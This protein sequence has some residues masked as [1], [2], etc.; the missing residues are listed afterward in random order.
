MFA[1]TPILLA[2]F[3]GVFWGALLSIPVGP[4]NLT[5]LN[6]GAHK[7]FKWALLIGLGASLMEMIYC[8]IA[9]TGFANFFAHGYHGYVKAALQ[10]CSFVFLLGLGVYFLTAPCPAENPSLENS[11][12][13]RIHPHA[14]FTTGLVRVLGNPGILIVWIFIAANLVERNLV[15]PTLPAKC[16]CVVGVACGTFLWFVALSYLVALGRRKVSPRTL[17]RIQKGSGLG[18]LAMGIFNGWGIVLDLAQRYRH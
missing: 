17:A 9:F 18:L 11:L 7:G 10:L 3:T 14:A 13:R 12:E 4:V 5:I 8:G 1:P 15:S 6:E 16:A 2:A